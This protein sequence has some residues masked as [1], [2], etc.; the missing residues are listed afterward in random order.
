[1]FDVDRVDSDVAEIAEEAEAAVV[2]RRDGHKLS[3]IRA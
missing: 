2:K 1:V 3:G